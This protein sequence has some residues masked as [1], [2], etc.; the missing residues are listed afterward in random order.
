MSAMKNQ[1]AEE[2]INRQLGELPTS[3]EVVCR[4][5]MMLR[6]PTQE[7]EEV[8]EVL[9]TDKDLT[10]QLVTRLAMKDKE[11]LK[12]GEDSM[13][14]K[15]EAEI[16]KILFDAVLH[17]GY[18][19]I[20]SLVSALSVGQILSAEFRGYGYGKR[21]LWLHSVTT[22][23]ATQ[24]FCEVLQ[25]SNRAM[26][27]PSLGFI[28]G[29]MHDIGKAGLNTDLGQD[30]QAVSSE[31]GKAKGTWLK[32]EKNLCGIDHAALGAILVK[33]W[34]LPKEIIDAIRHHHNPKASHQMAAIVHVADYASR[35]IS[36]TGGLANFRVKL[37]PEAL[38]FSGLRVDDI[39]R[40]ILNILNDQETLNLY[41]AN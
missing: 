33:R 14:S 17:M 30:P 24:R 5:M 18:R 23:L 21:E 40:V 11:K 22:A 32:L 20:L 41:T 7:N 6:N 36:A 29:V 13:D 12:Q 39:E 15:T 28:A 2:R 16:L 34:K 3:L 25:D 31:M 9:L 37:K 38:E 27:D 4:L 26:H 10:M 1:E 35:F 19:A 8:V